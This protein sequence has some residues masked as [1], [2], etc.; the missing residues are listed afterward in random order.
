M[1]RSRYCGVD[2]GDELSMSSRV[3][4]A[5][6]TGFLFEIIPENAQD[7][8]RVHLF[9]DGGVAGPPEARRLLAGAQVVKVEH[10]Q[11]V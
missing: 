9:G 5:I 8:A 10:A 1:M 3:P 4:Q 6:L 2:M 11:D 7:V